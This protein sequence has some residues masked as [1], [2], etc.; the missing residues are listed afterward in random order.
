[1]EHNT[2][3]DNRFYFGEDEWLALMRRA[4]RT[5]R[6]H[7]NNQDPDTIVVPITKMVDGV[8]I[9]YGEAEEPEVKKAK[10]VG[11]DDNRG[12]SESGS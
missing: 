11:M 3:R 5:Y 7:N 8:N 4:I 10:K 6:F 1:M 12:T 2:I 9:S